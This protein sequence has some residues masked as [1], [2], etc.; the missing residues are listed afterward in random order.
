[1]LNYAIALWW[2]LSARLPSIPR[3]WLLPIAVAGLAVYTF[4]LRCVHLFNADHFFVI[5]PDSYYFHWLAGRVLAGEGQ[6]YPPGETD[7]YTWHSGLAYPIAYISK[8]VSWIPGVT[9]AGALEFVCKFL[10]PLLGVVG[11]LIIFL[12][13]AKLYD[14]KVALFSAFAWGGMLHAIRHAGAAGNVDRD[15]LN[16]LLLMTGVFV[17]HLSRNWRFRIRDRQVGWAVAGIAL[18][19]I[20]AALYLEWNFIGPALLLTIM[21]SCSGF[22]F[23]LEYFAGRKKGRARRNRLANAARMA[24]WRVPALVIAVNVVAAAALSSQV[25]FWY[26][27]I[28]GAFS[29]AT[30][31]PISELQGADVPDYLSYLFFLIPMAAGLYLAWKTRHE[32]TVFVAFWFLLLAFLALFTGRAIVY[33]VPAACVL[34]GVGLAFIWDWGRQEAPR[35]IRKVALASLFVLIVL[36]ANAGAYG[37]GSPPRMAVDQDWH[38]A[39]VHI[40][41]QTPERSVVMTWWDYGYWILDLADRRPLVDGGYYGWDLERLTDTRAAYVA[42][43]TSEAAQVMEK[44]GAD[45]LIFSQLDLDIPYTIQAWPQPRTAGSGYDSFPADSLIARSLAGDLQSD[46]NLEVWYTS[47]NAEVVVLKRTQSA[48]P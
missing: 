29:G 5:K 30:E 28:S 33:A 43:A 20:E 25:D 8:A 4:F 21:A 12:V 31:S 44:Y 7:I 36:F 42:T 40:R 15:V 10:P 41:D 6:P 18:L 9:S 39:L 45:Y 35:H 27:T 46:D 24:N 13:A 14:K 37:L 48:G 2:M 38:D 22:K 47:P 32:A 17:F 34:S 26:T 19:V 1:M 16:I 23:L 3:S 11:M